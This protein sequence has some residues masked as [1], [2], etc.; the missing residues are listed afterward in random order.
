MERDVC[1]HLMGLPGLMTLFEIELERRE[2]RPL[3]KKT[4]QCMNN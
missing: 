3:Q 2:I 4:K 1:I